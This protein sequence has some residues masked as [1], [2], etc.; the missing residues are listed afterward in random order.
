VPQTQRA[1]E[2]RSPPSTTTLC[3]DGSSPGRD[4]R[5]RVMNLNQEQVDLLRAVAELEG[6]AGN[7]DTRKVGDRFKKAILERGGSLEWASSPPWYGTDPYAH[8]LHD[9]GLLLIDFGMPTPTWPGAEANTGP[10]LYPVKLTDAG[11]AALE[12]TT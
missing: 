1:F 7:T 10:D 4:R 3:G 6:E 5:V 9:Q 12:A 8:E 11:R 2:P